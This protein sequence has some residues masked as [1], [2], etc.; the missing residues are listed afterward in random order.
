[1]RH[2]LGGADIARK[3][4]AMVARRSD[5]PRNSHRWVFRI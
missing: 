4:L 3:R 5:Q 2:L 1:M